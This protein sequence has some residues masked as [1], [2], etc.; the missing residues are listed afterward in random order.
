M[1]SDPIRMVT[2]GAHLA[3]TTLACPR[4]SNRPDTSEHLAIASPRHAFGACAATQPRRGAG[5]TTATARFHAAPIKEMHMRKR[6]KQWTFAAGA[7]VLAIAGVAAPAFSQP[8]AYVEIRTYADS[9]G[10]VRGVQ[11]ISRGCV[12]PQPAG[13]GLWSGSFTTQRGTCFRIAPPGGELN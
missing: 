7:A 10:N 4:T 13:W 11:Y 5:A 1:P 12:D 3:Q 8:G 6:N 9:A 2:D